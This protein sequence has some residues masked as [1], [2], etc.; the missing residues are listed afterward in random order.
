MLFPQGAGSVLSFCIFLY[1]SRM[2]RDSGSKHSLN[3]IYSKLLNENNFD[4]YSYCQISLNSAIFSKNL[5]GIFKLLFL[6]LHSGE[7]R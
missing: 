1:M 7:K 4:F 6:S 3:L 2:R 5:L